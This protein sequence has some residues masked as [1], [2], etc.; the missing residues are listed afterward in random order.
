M[1]ALYKKLKSDPFYFNRQ[2]SFYQHLQ[3]VRQQ[4]RQNRVVMLTYP[5]DYYEWNK[6]DYDTY[7]DES[8][9]F[10]HSHKISHEDYNNNLNT[11]NDE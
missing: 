2:S 11:M 10:S 4:T 9:K 6:K 3:E 7:R 1:A 5:D 8:Y